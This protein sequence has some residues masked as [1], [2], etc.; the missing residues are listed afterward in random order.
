MNIVQKEKEVLSKE[1]RLEVLTRRKDLS[2]SLER[3][4]YYLHNACDQLWKE[5][6]TYWRSHQNARKENIR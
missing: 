1:N 4:K 3:E 6:S 5:I 2:P